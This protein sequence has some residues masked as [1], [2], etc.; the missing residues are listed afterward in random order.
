MGETGTRNSLPGEKNGA[1]FELVFDSV[2]SFTVWQ[3]NESP[4]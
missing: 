4:S 3:S 1:S 2:C